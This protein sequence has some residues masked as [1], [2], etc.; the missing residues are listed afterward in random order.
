MESGILRPILGPHPSALRAP[1]PAC[2]C[3][4][5][6]EQNCRRRRQDAEA[7]I[8]AAD[9]PEGEGQNALSNQRV[10]PP[11][12]L[13]QIRKTPRLGRFAYLAEREGFEPSDRFPHRQFSR[14]LPSTTRP[15]LLKLCPCSNTRVAR[16]IGS[17][18][19]PSRP[20]TSSAA[21]QRARSL[22]GSR[23]YAPMIVLL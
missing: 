13:R 7:N 16:H 3:P 1:G 4:Q 17:L 5:C 18:L 8:G 11:P 10:R 21:T 2:S 12:S 22:S 14:L 20:S 6:S 23:E 19:R 15:P 9:G